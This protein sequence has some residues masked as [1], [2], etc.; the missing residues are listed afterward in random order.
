MSGTARGKAP[1]IQGLPEQSRSDCRGRVAAPS[2]TAAAQAFPPAANLREP[3]DRAAS[4][5]PN[6][7]YGHVRDSHKI[8]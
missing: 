1:S 8:A 7:D 5:K 4:D 6:P 2:T 3:P